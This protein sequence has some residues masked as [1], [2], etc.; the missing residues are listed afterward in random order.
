MEDIDLDLAE[1][2]RAADTAARMA[3]LLAQVNGERS[4]DN[5][6]RDQAYTLL[7]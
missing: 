7:K 1:L 4:A 5:T 6:V 2:E 3:D